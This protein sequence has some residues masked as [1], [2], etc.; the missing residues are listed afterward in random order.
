MTPTQADEVMFFLLSAWPQAEKFW[1]TEHRDLLQE[2]LTKLDLAPEQ[3]I[4]RIRKLARDHGTT[5]PDLRKHVWTC[6]ESLARSQQVQAAT[7]PSKFWTLCDHL[8]HHWSERNPDA[9]RMSDDEIMWH[10]AGLRCKEPKGRAVCLEFETRALGWD[11]DRVR[12]L[13]EKHRCHEGIEELERRWAE[14][15]R[16]FA[17]RFPTGA[18][19]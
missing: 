6:L 17:V 1:P 2:D 14:T 5:L 12:A 18:P 15:E 8:R 16:L 13:L 7:E 9:A 10:Y 11:W 3:C 19:A 4:A